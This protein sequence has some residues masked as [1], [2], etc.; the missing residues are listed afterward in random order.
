[1]GKTVV[2]F[3]KK[4][5]GPEWSF[6]CDRDSRPFPDSSKGLSFKIW[7]GSNVD[8]DAKYMIE[9]YLYA[10]DDEVYVARYDGQK[11]CSRIIM[12]GGGGTA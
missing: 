11:T 9:V 3:P 8:S 10:Q 1:M 12:M 5:R 7:Y 6:S 2:I 4:K